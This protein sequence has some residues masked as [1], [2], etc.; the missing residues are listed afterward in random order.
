M[1]KNTIQMRIL[2]ALLAN[3]IQENQFSMISRKVGNAVGKHAMT[4]M[5]SRKLLDV[6]Q[7]F[8]AMKKSKT[9]SGNQTPSLMLKQ[10]PSR[11]NLPK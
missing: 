10:V 6:L 1:L 4:G 3:S 8:I 7:V 11:T 2:M 5:S 9:N